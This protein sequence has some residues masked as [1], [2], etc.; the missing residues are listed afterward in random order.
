MRGNEFLDKMGLVDPAY[1]EAADTEPKRKKRAWMKWAVA[2]ACLCLIAAV[3]LPYFFPKKAYNVEAPIGMEEPS[4]SAEERPSAPGEPSPSMEEIP[5]ASGEA[6]AA[7]AG[8]TSET[9]STLS[10]LLGYL[11]AHESHDDGQLYASDGYQVPAASE[12]INEEKEPVFIENTGVALSADGKYSY[13][14]GEDAVYISRLEGKNTQ[15]AGSIEGTADAIFACGDNLLVVSQF[16]SEGGEAV[17]EASV[18]VSIYD[19]AVSHE[20]VQKDEYVQLGELASCWML[21]D[22]LYF[23]T[24]DG[25]CAC[26][27]SR[28]DDV[29]LYYPSLQHNGEAVEWPDEDISILGEPTRVQYSAI[30]AIDG[31]SGQVAEKKALYG[32]IQDLFYGE[33]W[34]VA[35]VSAETLSYRE[36]PVLYTFGSGLG[37]TGKINAAE[38]MG[39]PDVNELEDGMPQAGSYLDIVSV[40]SHEGGYRLLGTFSKDDGDSREQSFMAIAANV[41]TGEAG[42]QLL[43]TDPGYPY[44]EFTEIRWEENRAVLCIGIIDSSSGQ[45]LGQE[46]RFLFAEFDGTDVKFQE[47]ELKADYLNSQVGVTY[48][49][50][51]G[52]FETLIPMGSGIYLRYSNPTEPAESPSGFDLFDFSDSAAPKLLHR[53]EEPLSGR[54]AFDY[55]WHVYDAHTFG[56]LKV[57]LGDGEEYY[58]NVKLAWCVYS[59]GSGSEPAVTLQE[60][61]LLDGEAETYVGAG[62][63]GFTVFE[64][65]GNLYYVTKYNGSAAAL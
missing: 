14:I 45:E 47:T 37:F 38:I 35:S 23:I 39:A 7:F 57:L 12:K 26:G 24:S 58:R 34:I 30:T 31:N 17:P 46:T 41:K 62:G 20:P 51:L 25:E 3:A 19:I 52:C 36:N 21:G 2:A 8:K 43:H 18:R 61:H 6:D 60:E 50:P 1:V 56:T 53:A 49:S 5:S 16:Y 11:S 54:D 27:W 32:N 9:Y 44:G 22:K 63:I 65:G 40:S 28:L 4:P 48:G 10:E 59:V 33:G 15:N 64:A 55:A 42:S 13:H 29:S